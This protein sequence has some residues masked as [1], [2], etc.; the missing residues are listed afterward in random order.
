M[1]SQ[2]HT[3]REKTGS[4]WEKHLFTPFREHATEA[5]VKRVEKVLALLVTAD[6][7]ARE[8]RELMRLLDRSDKDWVESPPE[9]FKESVRASS[10]TRQ[11]LNDALRRYRW[12]PLVEGG[13]GEFRV[14]PY[15]VTAWRKN[16]WA[17][18]ECGALG[19]LLRLANKPGELSRFRRCS[20]CQQWFY[21]IRGHQQFCGR[22]CR[23]RHTAQDPEFKE[24][25][26]TYMRET[27]RPIIE[28]EKDARS[29][30]QA[31][32]VLSEKSK[33]GGN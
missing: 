32:R 5:A 28:K 9:S 17:S 2:K 19:H 14:S 18:W 31:A 24:K 12:V 4:D 1:K 8:E 15:L 26:A 3:L 10:R 6:R 16:K 20:E 23:R 30:R 21:A 25:R 7:Q 27:Y 11:L 29:R 33:K 22:D 13:S